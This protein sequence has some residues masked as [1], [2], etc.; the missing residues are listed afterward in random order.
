MNR[1]FMPVISSRC[2]ALLAPAARGRVR[3]A[4]P[5]TTVPTLSRVVTITP[6]AAHGTT[7]IWGSTRSARTFVAVVAT[8]NLVAGVAIAKPAG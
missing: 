4:A 8:A 2:R 5:I 1:T 7:T 6:L 3:A